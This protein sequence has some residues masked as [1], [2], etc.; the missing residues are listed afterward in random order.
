MRACLHQC[1]DMEGGYC[2][3]SLRH[4]SIQQGIWLFIFAWPLQGY[5]WIWLW[6]Q[7]SSDQGKSQ[8]LTTPANLQVENAPVC[9][10]LYHWSALFDIHL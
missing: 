2:S 7:L 3:R 6:R 5:T 4:L 9:T 8:A 10:W 1:S